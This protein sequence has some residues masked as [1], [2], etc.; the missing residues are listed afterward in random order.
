M[1]TNRK[2]I[3]VYLHPLVEQALTAFCEQKN[4]KSKKGLMY[5][6]GVNAVLA[7]FFGIAD[8]DLG[9]N[10]SINILDVSSNILDTATHLRQLNAIQAGVSSASNILDTAT[11]LRQ[12]NAIQAGVSSVSNIPPVNAVQLG[13]SSASNIPP[14]NAVQVGVSSASNI[15]PV[16]AVQVGVSSVSNTLFP[17]SNIF[18]LASSISA[19]DVSN[20][21][22]QSIGAEVLPGKFQ[23]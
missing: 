3:A 13:V 10:V 2:H 7:E 17:E 22:F 15:P 4:L 9:T 8:T 12:L 21:L 20:K 16:N 1:A 6:A 11:H 5:S 14:V 23:A 18:A 19:A